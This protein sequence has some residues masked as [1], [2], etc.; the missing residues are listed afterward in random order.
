[1]YRSL[2]VAFAMLSLAACGGMLA[3][4]QNDTVFVGPLDDMDLNKMK[5][6]GQLQSI[7]SFDD[8]QYAIDKSGTLIGICRT[9][10]HNPNPGDMDF[11]VFNSLRQKTISE[12]H[13]GLA[14]KIDSFASTTYESLIASDPIRY[15]HCYNVGASNSNSLLVLYL[16]LQGTESLA[17]NTAVEIDVS[18]TSLTIMDVELFDRTSAPTRVIARDNPLKG[19]TVGIAN[20][21][22]EINGSPVVL[23]GNSVGA[24]SVK[25][26]FN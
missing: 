14:R 2:I 26:Q 9:E 10:H 23:N 1:M 12:T 3:Y 18:G 19:N 21:V 17:L 22:I 6:S 16:Q 8:M 4:D 7:G 13:S 20:G 15:L 24:A 5:S 11:N 25:H